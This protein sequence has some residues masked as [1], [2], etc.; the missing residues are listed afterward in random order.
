MKISSTHLL[1]FLALAAI[2]F[3]A[4]KKD[5]DPEDLLTGKSCWVMVKSEVL[6]TSTNQWEEDI[7]EACSQDDCSNFN[8][9]KT[10][11]V[12]EG[13]TKCDPDDPQSTSGT[14]LLSEDGKTL[15]ITEDNVSLPFTVTELSSSKMVLEISFIGTNPFTFESK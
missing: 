4:C 5:S 2:S 3:S 7:I 8:T 1:L 11:T 14:W 9:D 10:F 13:S 15:T 6:N 12:D